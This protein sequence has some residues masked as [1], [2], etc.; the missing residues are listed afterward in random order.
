MDFP[1]NCDSAMSHN[2]FS[3]CY[4]FTATTVCVID[5]HCMFFVKIFLMQINSLTTGGVACCEDGKFVI[6]PI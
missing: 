2:V 1:A 3:L 5:T 6:G 4:N